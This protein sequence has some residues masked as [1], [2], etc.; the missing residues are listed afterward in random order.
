MRGYFFVFIL[1]FYSPFLHSQGIY[2]NEFLASNSSTNTDPDFGEHSDRIELY[3]DLDTEVDLSNW[4]LTD[5]LSDSTK[6]QIPV[7]VSI[8]PKGFLTI[9]AD[10]YDTS[11]YHLHTSFRL[12]K[13]GE[14]IGLFNMDTILIDSI[15][16]TEQITDISSGRYPDGSSNWVLF[17]MPTL[18]RSNDTSPY[19]KVPKSEFSLSTMLQVSSIPCHSRLRVMQSRACSG[20]ALSDLPMPQSPKNLLA[21]PRGHSLLQHTQTDQSIHQEGFGD[22]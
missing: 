9:W 10:E 20:M 1:F 15:V 6:W 8:E 3:N 2:I 11:L 13:G 4:F 19:L 18:G 14:A 21:R 22:E 16:Y 12:S 7:G 17:D 5:I